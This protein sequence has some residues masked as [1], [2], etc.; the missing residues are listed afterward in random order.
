[1]PRNPKPAA[2][3]SSHRHAHVDGS[4]I[5]AVHDASL[6]AQIVRRVPMT[7]A[8]GADASLDRPAHVRAA[9]GIAWIGGALAVAQDDANFVAIVNPAN[10][11]ARAITLPAGHGGLRQFDDERGNKARKLDLEALAFVQGDGMSQLIALGSGSRRRRDRLV[12]VEHPERDEAEAQLFETSAFHDAMRTQRHFSGS[13]L[14]VEAAVHCGD[15]LR[16]FNRGNGAPTDEVPAVD[17]S[18]EVDWR[19]LI[20]YARQPDAA[21]PPP[22]TN[23]QPY[24]LGELDGTRLTFTDATLATQPGGADATGYPML[25]TA[26]AEAS[27]DAS[28][29]GDVA[30]SV[31]GIVRRDGGG[32]S[33]GDDAAR[34]VL[35]A[36]YALLLDE[37]GSVSKAKIEGIAL[38]PDSR[39]RLY[40][41]VDADSHDRPSELWE[42]ELQGPWY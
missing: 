7:Y 39:D 10:G 33:D 23:V 5:K 38:H 8:D 40:V 3:G 32:N 9:S 29:D 41:V 34:P 1:M 2:H 27:P 6:A 26:A 28:R 31:I 24:D 12:L 37:D 21:E 36:R 25:Y 20:A 17:A 22:I 15:V 4:V 35:S 16:I 18:C 14:N 30:G 42:V 11:S 13:E 19:A